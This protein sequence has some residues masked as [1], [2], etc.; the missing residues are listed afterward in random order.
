MRIAIHERENSYSAD[1]ISYCEAKSI[2]YKIVNCYENDIIDQLADC[3]ALMWH[4]SHAIPQ[5][6]IFARQ[7][8]FTMESSGKVVFPDFNTM[9]HFDDKIGQKYLLESIDAPLATSHVFY[10]KDEAL[11]WI[12]S[13][14]FPKVF[15]L[16]GGASSANVKLVKSKKDA[17]RLVN[18]AFGKGFKQF[19]PYIDLKE[20]IRK[21]KLGESTLLDIFTRILRIFFNSEIQKFSNREKGYL[22]FQEFI[23][24]NDSDIR[25]VVVDG[26]AFGEK[27]FVRENDF[28]ASGSHMRSYDKEII[29]ED[30]LKVA[31][32]VARKLKLQCSAFDFVYQNGNPVIVEISYG[33]TPAAYKPCPGFWDENLMFHEGTFNFCGWM[34]D[35]VIKTVQQKHSLAK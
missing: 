28:R 11:R 17:V 13:T 16:R 8:I 18:K 27:R 21:R 4:F 22:Y 9:W 34:V 19:S 15:K 3:D 7:L 29:T 31:F 24:N 10:S 32:E 1:W 26:K 6:I 14:N 20:S 23:A 12:N 25:L 2:P 33:T 5:D 30:T 35:M